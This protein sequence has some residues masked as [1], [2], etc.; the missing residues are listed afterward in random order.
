MCEFEIGAC[1]NRRC[2]DHE[3]TDG[4]SKGLNNKEGIER[5][6]DRETETKTEFKVN[7]KKRWGMDGSYKYIY[8]CGRR[9]EGLFVVICYI[10][11]LFFLINVIAMD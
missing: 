5:E 7:R 2:Y 8:T 9:G 1:R 3:K 6:R 10:W 11:I 4:D